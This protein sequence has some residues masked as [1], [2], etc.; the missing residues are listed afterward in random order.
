MK[1]VL[2]CCAFLLL[3]NS[4]QADIPQ[5]INFQGN[6]SSITGEPVAD[7]NYDITIRLYDSEFAAIGTHVW[8]DIFNTQTKQGNFTIELGSG[9]ASLSGFDFNKKYWIGIQV[10]TSS[11]MAKRLPLLSVPYA[12]QAQTASTANAIA[13]GTVTSS[14]VADNAIDNQAKA[15]WSPRVQVNGSWVNNPRIL[16][17]TVTTDTY[18]L[19]AQVSYADAGFTNI[20]PILICTP[21]NDDHVVATT[22][23]SRGLAIIKAFGV[24]TINAVT[25]EPISSEV[26]WIMIGY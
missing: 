1:K 19:N 12:M 3:L 4:T 25:H 10:G 7:G 11:E 17:G 2:L 15:P 23:Q 18:G 6:L 5:T 9:A 16:C 21:K 20:P 14:K 22:Y 8:S 26:H 24:K 13:D